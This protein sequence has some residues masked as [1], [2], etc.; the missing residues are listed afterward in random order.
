M[1]AGAALLL[2]GATAVTPVGWLLLAY[3]TF[4]VGNAMVNPPITVTAVSGMPNARAGVAAA[5]ASTSRQVGQ[6]LGV[7]VAGSVVASALHGSLHTG[8]TQAS[9]AGWLLTAGC[10]ALVF[11]FGLASSGRWARATA[12]RTA[13]MVLADEPRVPVGTP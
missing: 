11:V 12:Q 10:G 8:F 1:M 2:A 6:T 3:V 4:G 5:V 9:H 13:S 7:A